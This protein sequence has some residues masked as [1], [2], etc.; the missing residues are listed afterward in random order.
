MP[1]GTTDAPARGRWFGDRRV[2]RL[3]N[4]SPYTFTY[5]G[6]EGSPYSAFFT[7][8]GG[9]WKANPGGFC[10]TCA[11]THALRPQQEIAV[12]MLAA[13][14]VYHIE[15]GRCGVGAQCY[16]VIIEGSNGP[17]TISVID[18]DP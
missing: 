13:E 3:K 11:R 1:A 9:G 8:Y 15:G 16:E 17:E 7:A 5:Y 2:V 18:P 6:W 4:V 12:E 10:T 14:Y